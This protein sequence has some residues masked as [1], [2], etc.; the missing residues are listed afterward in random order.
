MNI[1][2]I[3]SLLILSI[4]L[5]KMYECF[6]YALRVIRAKR[7]KTNR[8]RKWNSF[9]GYESEKDMVEETLDRR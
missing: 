2:I 9:T 8:P 4:A 6:V 3:A 5:I 1:L 7:W